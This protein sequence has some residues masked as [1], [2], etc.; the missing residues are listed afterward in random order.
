MNIYNQIFLI[1][2]GAAIG[3]ISGISTT[4]VVDLIKRQGQVR[5]YYKI[6][7]SKINNRRTW[8][9]HNGSD[10]LI[11]DVPLWLEVQNTSNAVRVIRDLNILLFRDGKELSQMTQINRINNDNCYGDDGSYS[12]VLQPRSLKKY[13]CNFTIKKNDM[14]EHC[15]FDEIRLR[16]FDDKD[17][18]QI[19]PLEAIDSCWEMGDL[20]REGCWKLAKK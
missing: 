20:N 16:Y 18:V 9:F 1:I 4:V 19:F 17:K 11:F 12:F 5:L 10:G 13:D 7:Y 6:V 2:I 8:G 15:L 14:G 3:F